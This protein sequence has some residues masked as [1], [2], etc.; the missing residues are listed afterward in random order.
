MTSHSEQAGLDVGR[1]S[2]AFLGAIL[3]AVEPVNGNVVA[4]LVGDRMQALAASTL[5]E[6]VRRPAEIS[7]L[8]SPPTAPD[9]VFAC[10]F[11]PTAMRDACV[12]LLD[13]SAARAVVDPLLTDHVQARGAG[14]LLD[15]ERGVLEYAV[16]AWADALGQRLGDAGVAPV[17]RQVD[18]E[19]KRQGSSPPGAKLIYRQLVIPPTRGTLA[20]SIPA[21]LEMRR[22]SRVAGLSDGIVTDDAWLTSVCTIRVALSPI[23]L[24]KVDTASLQP[25]D[26]LLVGRT[27]LEHLSAEATLCSDSGWTIGRVQIRHDSAATLSVELLNVDPWPQSTDAQSPVLYALLGRLE[28]TGEQLRSLRNGTVLDLQQSA[29]NPVLLRYGGNDFARGELVTARS[30]I[31][32]RITELLAGSPT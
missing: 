13:E 14:P 12:L 20:V 28:I 11:A 6:V 29:P 23:R 21:G 32:V 18:H 4:A 31:G 22:L 26:A 27:S 15:A 30:E 25:G 5:S 7:P 19:P 8:P 10:T 1:L 24:D 9:F 2:P 16:E 3:G 17:I